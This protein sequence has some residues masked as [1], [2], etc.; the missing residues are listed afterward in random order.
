MQ[1]TKE[2]INSSEIRLSL[3][4]SKLKTILLVCLISFTSLLVRQTLQIQHSCNPMIHWSGELPTECQIATIDNL[5]PSDRDELSLPKQT[6]NEQNNNN[7]KPNL[8]NSYNKTVSELETQLNSTPNQITY[9]PPTPTAE[10]LQHDTET[11]SKN[12]LDVVI[13]AVVVVKNFLWWRIKRFFQ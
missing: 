5:N 2:I 3:T 8:K 12:L 10:H 9:G 13:E 4:I 7:L 6:D 1:I 11:E